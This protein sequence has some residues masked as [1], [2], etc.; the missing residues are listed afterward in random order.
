MKKVNDER[1]RLLAQQGKKTSKPVELNLAILGE[2]PYEWSWAS[3]DQLS[4]KVVDG[5][6]KKPDYVDSGIPFLTVRNLTAGPGISFNRTS[7]VA[8]KDHLEF[9]K[10]ANPENGDILITKDGTLGVVRL[11]QTDRI[12]SIFVS[13]A[14]IK[15]VIRTFGPYLALVLAAPQVHQSIVKT[16]TGLQHIHLRD[17]RATAVPIPPECEQQEIVRRVEALSKTADALEARYFKAKAHVDKLT[18]SILA[19]AFRGELVPQD[20]TDE[21]ASG[22]LERIQQSRNGNEASKRR[23]RK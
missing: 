6:H 4:T 3:V 23:T 19:K 12:F 8:E 20:P 7:F 10:R 15:P 22:L 11:I 16:G 21:P 2:L 5:V 17:L 9:I 1:I 14:M 13:L 18:Q